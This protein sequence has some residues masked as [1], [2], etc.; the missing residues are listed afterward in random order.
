VN[1]RCVLIA[2]PNWIMHGFPVLYKD[3]VFNVWKVRM[4]KPAPRHVKPYIFP[5]L[6]NMDI[7]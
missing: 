1:S 5:M 3:E 6:K 7:F 4:W 2:E